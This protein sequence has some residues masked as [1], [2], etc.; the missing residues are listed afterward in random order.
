MTERKN[1]M[2]GIRGAITVERDDPDEIASA[3]LLLFE[4]M[5][6]KNKLTPDDITALFI[7]VTPD[8]RS[9][10]P[11]QTIRQVEDYRFVPIMCSQE[12][13]VSGS[14]ER[15][16]RLMAIAFCPEANP[17][18]IRHIYLRQAQELRP[19]LNGG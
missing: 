2:R 14:L 11:A 15:C 17:D 6:E 7:T 13:P 18:S 8:L 16:I 5:V 4:T 10:F 12:V 3:V 19:D 9:V 1:W